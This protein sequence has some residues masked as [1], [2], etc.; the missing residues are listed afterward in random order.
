M[1]APGGR[2]SI[3]EPI[4]RYFYDA[5][6]RHPSSFDVG[7]IADLVS[8]VDA[9][10]RG[11]KLGPM[12][13]FGERD[14]LRLAEEVGFA[15]MHLRLEVDVRPHQPRHWDAFYR[16]SPNPLAPTIEEALHR[17]LTPAEIERYVAYIRPIVESGTGTR[18]R[19]AAYLT[20]VKP[21]R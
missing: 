10:F 11:P 4:N 7:P 18:R 8:R 12:I 5:D 1:L 20:A 2:L 6:G 15:E 16:S 9:E 17:S 14:L 19:A 3:F 13:D 21:A